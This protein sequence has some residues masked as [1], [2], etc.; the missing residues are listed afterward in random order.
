MD[1]GEKLNEMLEFKTFFTI[2]VFSFELPITETV[3][4]SWAVMLG[5]IVLALVLGR[6]LTQVPRGA[7]CLLEAGVELLDNMSASY[8]GKRAAVFSPYIGTIF[9]FL[10]F[11]NIIPAL[12]PVSLAVAGHTFTPP[13]EIKPPTRDINFTAALAVMSIL[14]VL[15][16]GIR[17]R[18]LGG[19]FKNLFHPVPLMLPFNLLEYAIRPA[20]MCLRLFGNML[21]GFIIMALIG[22]VAPVFIPP[23]FSLY[24]DFLDGLIQALVF[25]FL[26][27]LFVSEA[28]E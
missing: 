13:F 27:I 21:G 5:I 25:T 6:K 16:S 3:I 2:R 20:S 19:W 12:T 8:F 1:I 7:Q 4:V 11:A 17:F 18:G 28:V 24:F 26:T 15:F 23:V 22:S 10:L 9:I 14:L